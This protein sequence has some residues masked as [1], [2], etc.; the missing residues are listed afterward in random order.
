[1]ATTIEKF[2]N[3]Y[4]LIVINVGIIV[5]ALTVGGGKLFFDTGLIHII[6]MLF[7]ALAISRIFFH[8]YTYDPIL[9][10]FVHAN[11]LAMMVFALSHVFEFVSFV[12]LREYPD[13]VFANVANLYM[14]SLF[15]MIIGAGPFV[16]FKYPL[17]TKWARVLSVAG[18]VTLL[19]LT[20]ATMWSDT[21]VSLDTDDVAPYLYSLILG[22][23]TA[24]ALWEVH[25]IKVIAP[26][27]RGFASYL[28]ATIL[29]IAFAALANILYEFL[30]DYAGVADYLSI[31]LSHFAF[32]A[33]LSIFFLAFGEFR[34][35]GGVFADIN[36]FAE[37]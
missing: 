32:Y 27:A 18:I 5:C 31:Y 34:N 8:H 22:V 29:L 21:V 28:A 24:L 10:K 23:T 17:Y 15:I 12:I 16:A 33:A 20:A 1:M 7:V 19:F 3:P 13:T 35:L 26:V 25:K 36:K 2:F 14:I 30:K 37:R 9:E 4:L 11:L 6:A